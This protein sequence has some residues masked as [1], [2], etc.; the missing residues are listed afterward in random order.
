MNRNTPE[1]PFCGRFISRPDEIKTGF[2]SVL[3]GS[4]ECGTIYVC[5]P[6]G[7][8]TGEA[9]MEALALAKGNWQISGI[10]EDVDYETVN[11]DYDEKSH[12]VL[13][14]KG[15]T[16]L[17][18]RLVFIKVKV[19]QEEISRPVHRDIIGTIT[20][21][22]KGMTKE[23]VRD[24]LELRACDEVAAMARQNKGVIRWLISFTYDKQDVISWRAI[25]AIGVI[26]RTFSKEMMEALRDTIR[27]L[28][29]SMGEESGGIGWSAAEMLGEIVSGDPDA[30][31][32]IIPIIWSFK[33]EEMFRAGIVWAMG[34]I[35]M[36]RPELVSFVL[37]DLPEMM[38]DRNPVVRGYTVRLMGLLPEALSTGSGRQQ[39]SK[40]LDDTSPVPVYNEGE[41]LTRTVAEI[42]R[43]VLHK[44]S[45]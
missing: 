18:G 11:L 12:Q 41:L 43:E 45:K 16:S 21:G 28:L 22:S 20:Q 23:R 30:F 10:E 32:D 31:N 36:L 42:A 6:T 13:Y 19:R 4:C 27:R 39:I 33:E 24:L 38:E 17:S 34:R 25:E 1:C 2:G 26:S 7:H 15:H 8:N 44:A 29:W 3:G 40:L 5:D 9:Y 35:A 14:S 37:E